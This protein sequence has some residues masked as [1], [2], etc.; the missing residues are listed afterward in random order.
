MA[1]A[2]LRRKMFL[3]E[4]TD[5]GVVI[6]PFG[7]DVNGT[8]D[9]DGLIGDSLVSAAYSEAG[10]YLCT[11]REEPAVCFGGDVWVSNTTDDVDLYGKL[12]WSTV[13]AGTFTVR[14]MTGATQTTPTNNLKVGGFLLVKKTTREARR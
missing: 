9:A 11:L 8:S 1:N 12:D 10:E 5:E 2:R 6:I 14:F 4:C 7:F 13:T 3:P